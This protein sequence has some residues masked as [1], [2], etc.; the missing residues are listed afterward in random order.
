MI[1]STMTLVGARAFAAAFNPDTEHHA[2]EA[3]MKRAEVH[4]RPYLLR[5][6]AEDLAVL[7]FAPSQIARLRATEADADLIKI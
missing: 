6:S 5:L 7:G 1:M 4:V 2:I 3:R